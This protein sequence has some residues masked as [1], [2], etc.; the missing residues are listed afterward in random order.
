M[1]K[2]SELKN[3]LSASGLKQFNPEYYDFSLPDGLDEKCYKKSYD[4]ET[5]IF[6]ESWKN[7]TKE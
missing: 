1:N 5:S 2:L 3:I 7:T 6:P 4:K